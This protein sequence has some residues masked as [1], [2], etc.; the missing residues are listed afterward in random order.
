MIL[1]IDLNS[2]FARVEQQANPKLRN[3][4][5]GVLGKGHKGARTCICAASPEAKRYG[6]K[7]GCSVREAQSLCPSLILVP[8]DYPKYLDISRRFM[9]IL[10]EFSPW[11]EIFS[12]DEAFLG[13]DAKQ[14]RHPDKTDIS[15]AKETAIQIKAHLKKEF[16]ELITVTIGIAWGKVFA[17]LAGELHKPDGLVVLERETWLER[18][19]E[20]NVGEICG[21]G[22]R[23]A[24]HLETMGIRTIRQLGTADAGLFVARFGPATGMRL[25]QIGQ[26]ID[27]A[28]VAPSTEL[29]PMKSIGHQVTLDTNEFWRAAYPILAKLTQ[30]VGRRLRR[31]GLKAGRLSLHVASLT[32]VWGG[33]RRHQPTISSDPALLASLHSL[34]QTAPLS[35]ATRVVR[36]GVVVSDVQAIGQQVLP[37]F[38]SDITNDNLTASLDAVRDRYGEASIE[39][40]SG[41]ATNLGDLRDWRGPRAVLDI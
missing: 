7:S 8:P 22:T 13:L 29:P 18:V 2:F 28:P 34:W 23:L 37:I 33:S 24:A 15:R 5:I 32:G 20:M 36:L 25:W 40:G 17:K 1:H 31:A 12:I 14:P 3:R 38:V 35:R 9:A 19:G 30:K 26:G 21:I 11:I 41:F 16:G 10:E 27:A 6:I 4:P 39:W